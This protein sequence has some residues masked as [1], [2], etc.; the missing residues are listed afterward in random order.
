VTPTRP[1]EKEALFTPA[2]TTPAEEKTEEA[3]T[4]DTPSPTYV[5]NTGSH[6]FHLPGCKSVPTIKAENRSDTQETRDELMARGYSP[7]GSCKP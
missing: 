5:L 7:C 3:T 2:Q 4:G 6:K 1:A